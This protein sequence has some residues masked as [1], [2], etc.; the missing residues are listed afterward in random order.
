M[1]QHVVCSV[2]DIPAGS[3]KRVEVEGRDVA[4]FNVGGEFK[5]ISNRCPHEGANLCQG[6]IAAFADAAGPGEYLVEEERQ[7]VRCPW[8]GWEFDLATGRSY[9]DPNR[10]RVKSFDV[11]V[12]AGSGLKEGPYS[13]EIFDVT[14]EGDYVVLTI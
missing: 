7:M 9:C 10:V 12:S 14:T 1:G 5:A 4:L 3:S 6:R 8:H 11:A 13:I 2:N